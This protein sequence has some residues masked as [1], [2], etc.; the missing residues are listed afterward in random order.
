MENSFIE[1]KWINTDLVD[2]EEK[3]LWCAHWGETRMIDHTEQIGM[4]KI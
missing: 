1:Q 3:A 2:L 4:G